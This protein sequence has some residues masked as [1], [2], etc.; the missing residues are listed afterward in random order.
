M[1]LVLPEVVVV[2]S[3]FGDHRDAILGIEDG[4][5]ALA[6]RFETGSG[7]ELGGAFLV[8]FAHP[9]EGSLTADLLEPEVGILRVTDEVGGFDGSVHATESDPT[10]DQRHQA[11]SVP[12]IHGADHSPSGARRQ[13]GIRSVMRFRWW[14][15]V[16]LPLSEDSL[17]LVA[18]RGWRSEKRSLTGLG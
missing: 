9:G 18:G 10:C 2:R 12:S 13:A 17:G 7:G 4:K 11:A 16:E 1:A 15:R 5:Q 3:K 14:L 8:L 6:K